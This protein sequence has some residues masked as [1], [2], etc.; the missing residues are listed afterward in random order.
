MGKTYKL[1]NAIHSFSGT[2]P[3]QQ[4]PAQLVWSQRRMPPIFRLLRGLAD[5]VV[6]KRV[7]AV[8]SKGSIVDNDRFAILLEKRR[9]A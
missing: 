3:Y 8:A 5:V 7:R 6:I 4:L 1:F 9:A 2:M